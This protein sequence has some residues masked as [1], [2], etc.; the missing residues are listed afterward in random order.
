MLAHFTTFWAFLSPVIFRAKRIL[1]G[2]CHKGLGWDDSV[3]VSAA[4]KLTAWMKEMQKLNGFTISSCLKPA[5]FGKIA[6]AQLHHF[7][8]AS[9]EGY[10]IIT[11]LLLHNHQGL[12]HNWEVQG[13]T[14]K[15]SDDSTYGTESSCSGGSDG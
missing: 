7:V 6:A 15:A 13:G 10:G 5:S 8:D 2:L 14:S 12:A 3:P 1:Q 11:Y 4:Q 9:E